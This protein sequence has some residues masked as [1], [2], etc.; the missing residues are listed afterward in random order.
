MKELELKPIK[1]STED[2]EALEREIKELFRQEIYYPLLRELQAPKTTIQ[3]SKDEFLEAIRSGR[4][5]FHIK[6]F[7]GKFSAAISKELKKLGAIWDKVQKA[8]K[9]PLASLPIEVKVAISLSEDRIKET[10]SGIDGKLAKIV[11]EE[12]AKKFSARNIFERLIKKTDRSF[13]DS[14]RD[15]IVLPQL[16]DHARTRIASEWENNMQ[17][18]I[19]DFTES[20][21][22]K[23]RKDL[24]QSTFRGNRHEG[25]IEAIQDSYEV[26]ANK[27][28][29]LARQE[30][31]LLMSK[32]KEVRYADSGVEEYRWGCV[33]GTK[34]HPVR[35]WHKALEG[36]VFRWDDPPITSKPGEAVHRNNPGEDFNCRCFARPIVRFK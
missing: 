23:L 10:L 18:W 29:F 24:Q 31:S 27:A 15:I 33:A 5:T 21:I 12:V 20:E 25:M 13:H 1:E 36:K 28:K 26:S 22:Q 2:Y 16:T 9:I 4:I 30:T 32:F 6:V 34:N 35:P 14:V 17:L 11:P 3:N 8:W 19:K 7:F